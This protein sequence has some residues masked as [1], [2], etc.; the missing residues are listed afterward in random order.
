M[1]NDKRLEK[2]EGAREEEEEEE[3]RGSGF[4]QG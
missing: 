2:M 4:G 3:K 1:R